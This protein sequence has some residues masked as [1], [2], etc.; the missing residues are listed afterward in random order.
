MPL[1]NCTYS[2]KERK[3]ALKDKRIWNWLCYEPESTINVKI[4]S[5]KPNWMN[6]HM[7]DII[8]LGRIVDYKMSL[9]LL[10]SVLHSYILIFRYSQQDIL[11]VWYFTHWNL[12][13]EWVPI[14]NITKRKDIMLWY[15]HRN[16]L[17]IDCLS[18]SWTRNFMPTWTNAI[19]ALLH[20]VIVWKSFRE[21]FIN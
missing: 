13:R 20:H 9:H 15:Y 7:E 14:K 18:N 11:E 17:C 2:T 3:S 19:L 4:Q 6:Y 16:T 10:H 1:H 5:P 12:N 21:S 8:S